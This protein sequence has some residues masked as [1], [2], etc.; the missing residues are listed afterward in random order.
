MPN[1]F[2]LMKKGTTESIAFTQVDAEICAHFVVDCN[3][4][5]WF[6]YW[7]PSIMEWGIACGRT[8]VKQRADILKD[9]HEERKK[10]KVFTEEYDSLTVKD[11]QPLT[12]ELESRLCNLGHEIVIVNEEI[13]RRLTTLEI[14]DWLDTN[15]DAESWYQ[16]R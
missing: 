9:L 13:A 2:K 5:R 16:Q 10:R 4:I 7:Y 3:A 11:I 6:H 14:L 8:F 1:Y 15:Y 12:E